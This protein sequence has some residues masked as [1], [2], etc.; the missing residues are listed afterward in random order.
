MVASTHQ[1]L[2]LLK[3]VN[4]NAGPVL[5]VSTLVSWQALQ[6]DKNTAFPS[7]ISYEMLSS[8]SGFSLPAK[9]NRIIEKMIITMFVF[10]IF[11]FRSNKDNICFVIESFDN[12]SFYLFITKRIYRTLFFI[13]T[14]CISVFADNNSFYKNV[15]L[16]VDYAN[17]VLKKV[18]FFTSTA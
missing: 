9:A 2:S 11:N 10:S 12:I 4:P 7:T 17:Q 1:F 5:S 3:T 15:F 8:T 14:G 6:F 18:F 13:R 16:L